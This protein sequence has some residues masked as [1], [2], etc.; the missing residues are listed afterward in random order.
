MLT[1]EL[2]LGTKLYNKKLTELCRPIAR[3]LGITQAVYV[4]I[5]KQGRMFTI[6]SNQKMMENYIQQ[7]H[8]KYATMYVNPSNMHNGFAV[9]NSAMDEKY[10]NVVLYDF[11]TKFNWHNSFLYA[12]KDN[13]GGYFAI[14]FATTADNYQIFNKLMNESRIVKK[15]IRDLNNKVTLMVNKD[16]QENRMDFASLRGDS[17]HSAKGRVFHE[18]HEQQHKLQLLK[19]SKILTDRD[20]NDFL[21]K[22]HLSP[23]ETNCLKIY[24][25]T[26][27]VKVVAR[28]LD[29]ATTTVTSYIEN[30][31]N[32]LNCNNKNELFEKA[33][34]LESLGY[35]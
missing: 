1:D 11:I 6:T 28:D 24:Q 2:F 5:D 20:G 27:S 29:L 3:Y 35:I 18:Q 12:E 26:H 31:K 25:T 21:N 15:M 32:K 7:Q 22:I 9:D 23:Q 8:Y 13:M 19:E 4:H 17:F 33:D 14:D 10:K 30:I 34:I 16:L